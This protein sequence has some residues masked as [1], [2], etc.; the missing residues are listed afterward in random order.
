M[1]YEP[2]DLRIRKPGA[3]VKDTGNHVVDASKPKRNRVELYA[4]LGALGLVLIVSLIG[5][6]IWT[7]L[8]NGL[9]EVS[10]MGP[11]PS[12]EVSAKQAIDLDLDHLGF[13]DGGV[14][15]IPDDYM[16]GSYVDDSGISFLLGDEPAVTIWIIKYAN[17][18][19]AKSALDVLGTTAACSK[20][21]TVS[22]G[23][24]GKLRC[25]MSDA[26]E[27]VYRNDRW[28]VDIIAFDTSSHRPSDLANIVRD[29]LSDHWAKI[30][31]ASELLAHSN[32]ADSNSGPVLL[33][34]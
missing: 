24:R 12:A 10:D 4:G 29:L 27:S 15:R 26:H 21:T 2:G 7:L 25:T 9:A 32:P 31:S 16:P 18:N 19:A 30:R 28:I 23:D 17:N 5:Y 13:S 1:K 34:G 8:Q 3:D 33:S 11:W 22:I 20:L 6:G 14:Y